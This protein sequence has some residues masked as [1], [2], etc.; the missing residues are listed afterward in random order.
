MSYK[1]MPPFKVVVLSHIATDVKSHL[2]WVFLN[3]RYKLLT[4][5][6]PVNDKM[7]S[8][9]LIWKQTLMEAVKKTS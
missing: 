7:T 2:I 1:I 3:L 6:V 8:K 4:G 9:N 5:T